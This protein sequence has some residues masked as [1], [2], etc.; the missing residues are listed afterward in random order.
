MTPYSR[1]LEVLR[2]FLQQKPDVSS[3][4]AIQAITA[5]TGAELVVVPTLLRDGGSWRARVEL[6][7]PAHRTVS[8]STD[9]PG[10]FVV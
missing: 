9:Q 2:R 1:V 4:D 5:A 3:R 6:R 8:G 10:G 7:D